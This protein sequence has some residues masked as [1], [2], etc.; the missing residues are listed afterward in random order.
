MAINFRTFVDED[1][2]IPLRGTT[3]NNPQGVLQHQHPN[4]R[5]GHSKLPQ[6]TSDTSAE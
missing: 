3:Q 2:G 5:T 1:D 4:L 6:D